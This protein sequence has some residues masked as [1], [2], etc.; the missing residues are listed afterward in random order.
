[1]TEK[2]KCAN[3]GAI[4]E[5]ADGLPVKYICSGC[6]TLNTPKPE[7]YGSGEE[8]CGC[9]LPK[10]HEW[11]LPAGKIGDPRGS[12]YDSFLTADDGTPIKRTKWIE[13]YGYDPEV[14]WQKLRAQ[15]ENGVEGYLNLST[16]GKRKR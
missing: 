3:C 5:F 12:L 13:I 1:M 11:L 16:L 2:A 14:L 8:A 15:G 10:R 6:G 4:T 9:I 7:D